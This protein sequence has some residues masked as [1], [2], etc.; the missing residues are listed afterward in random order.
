MS[1]LTKL[2]SLEELDD[3]MGRSR[4]QPVWVFKHSLTCPISAVALEEFREFVIDGGDVTGHALIEVQT[5]REL[6]D[7]LARRTGVRHESPQALLLRNDQAVWHASH[8]RIKAD[9]L[10]RASAGTA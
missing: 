2:S 3:W 4:R 7:E 1:D 9:S 8:S 5:A 10:R 6:S